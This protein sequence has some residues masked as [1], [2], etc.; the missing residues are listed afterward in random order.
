MLKITAETAINKNHLDFQKPLED[1]ILVDKEDKIFIVLD[2]VTRDK[3]NGIYPN[4]S[5]SFDVSQIFAQ[6]V[7]RSLKQEKRNKDIPNLLKF[8]VINGNNKIKEYNKKGT[9]SFL[10]G[11][12]GIISVIVDDIFYYLFVGDCIGQIFHKNKQKKITYPQTRLI[13][14]HIT[15]FSA[16][17]IRNIICNNKKHP[18]GY[19]VFTGEVGVLDFLEFGNESLYK[20]DLILLA[21]DGMDI[22]FNNN[23]FQITSS[24]SAKELLSEAEKMENIQGQKSDDK[25]VILVRTG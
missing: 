15:E 19:G 21:T 9:W 3:N 6:E 16:D 12:V 20:G 1:F 2:G 4:P 7:Y 10:P 13:K 14:E 22:L 5:P 8:A 23:E 17:Q 25:A 24:T 11:T 18:Y